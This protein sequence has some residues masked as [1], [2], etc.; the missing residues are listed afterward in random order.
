MVVFRSEELA[1]WEI[2]QKKCIDNLNDKVGKWASLLLIPLAV[3]VFWGVISRYFLNI[4][5][6]WTWDLSVQ[7]LA[8]LVVLGGGY[9][10]YHDAHVSVDLIVSHLPLRIQCMGRIIT[11]GFF[12]VGIG[13]LFWKTATI[14][15]MSLMIREKYTSV[16]EFPIYP[17]KLLM[18]FGILL[19]LLEG[20]SKLIR[21]INIA[22]G[23]DG[24]KC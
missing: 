22:A 13:V 14:A 24:R 5:S 2:L 16:T 19:L 21:D 18:V 11:S 17:L 3:V 9:A 4:S 10:L 12:F 7:M 1:M 15:W 20:I 23:G 8:A 6:P